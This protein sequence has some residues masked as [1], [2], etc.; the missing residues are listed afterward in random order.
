MS[1]A[2]IHTHI[3]PCIDDGADSARASLEL[4]RAMERQGIDKIVATPHFYADSTNVDTFLEKRQRSYELLAS[5]A[6][7]T[8]TR[9]PEIKLGAEVH[10]FNGIGN[11]EDV[12]RL[13]MGRGDYILLELR[14]APITDL[15]IRDILNLYNSLS[16]F[17]V[18]AHIERFAGERGF[19]RMVELLYDER[20]YAQLNAESLLDFGYRRAAKRLVKHRLISF[21]ATDTHSIKERPPLMGEALA[22]VKKR[23]GVE[24]YEAFVDNALSFFEEI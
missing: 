14:N 22:A 3:L 18:M 15:V 17:P 19:E 21:I 12:R 24:Q 2:D 13:A 4:I 1:I 23:F 16:L 9:L 11:S 10:Y 8:N 5:E 20:A 7:K 6:E